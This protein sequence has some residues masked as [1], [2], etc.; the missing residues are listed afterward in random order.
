MVYETGVGRYDLPGE[1]PGKSKP[2]ALNVGHLTGV[3]F[4]VLLLLSV[5]TEG[6][7]PDPR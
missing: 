3:A 7:V 1:P 5:G 4:A 2:Q 6:T